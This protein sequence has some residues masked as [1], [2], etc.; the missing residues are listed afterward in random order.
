MT[1]FY[2]VLDNENNTLSFVNCGHDEPLWYHASQGSIS[3]LTQC[4][5]ALGMLPG[6][7]YKE[8]DLLGLEKDDILVFYTDGITEAMNR[9]KELLGAARLEAVVKKY[10][11]GNAAA[12]QNQVRQAV[13]K[14]QH[15]AP[16]QDDMSM[17]IIKTK[18]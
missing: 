9:D 10:A 7:V 16:Q 12:L 14:F 13:I 17:I 4:G 6:V 5:L 18:F 11:A 1:L 3:R 8:G 2:G 15:G